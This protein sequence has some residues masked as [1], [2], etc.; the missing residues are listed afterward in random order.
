MARRDG[1][2]DRFPRRLL[3]SAVG[4]LWLVDGL[5]QFRP[6]MA[7][8]SLAMV[9]MGGWDQPAWLLGAVDGALMAIYRHHMLL[10]FDLALGLGQTAIGA[11][12][13]AAGPDGRLGRAALRASLVAAAVVW[14]LGEWMGGLWTFPAGG[15]SFLFGGP[16]P[17]VPYAAAAVLLLPVGRR[18]GPD[19][20]T[21]L[22]RV[23][24]GLWLLGAAAQAVPALWQRP[25]LADAF[26]EAQVLTR[27][28]WW[29][30]P[31][32]A[33]S[34]LAAHHPALV[35]ALALA[36]VLLVAL[37]ALRRRRPL[38]VHLFVLAFL[39]AVW[40]LGEN[41][42]GLASGAATDPSSAPAWAA[43]YLPL[44][45]RGRAARGSGVLYSWGAAAAPWR[46]AGRDVLRARSEEG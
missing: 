30:R 14:A 11:I 1:N 16:G 5:L 40:W 44:W 2:D 38:A 21:A 4:A 10:P 8:N 43:L 6:E 7:M 42:G 36:A 41:F 23:W 37:G 25:A 18:L 46:S 20:P 28:A 3:A 32:A 33:A 17:V 35:N 31:I 15:F 45:W 19:L 39:A 22:S 29:T 24:A 12:L 9:A 34:A 13:L 26:A 27:Q